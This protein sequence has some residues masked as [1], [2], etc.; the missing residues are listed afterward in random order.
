V[1]VDAVLI[2][3]PAI[4]F[5]TFLGLTHEALGYSPASPGDASH[6]RLSDAERFLS[7]LEALRDPKAVP[8]LRPSLL[9]HV[10][11]SVLVAADDRD[12]IQIVEAAAG[13]PFVR[14]E[15]RARGIDLA[16]VTGTLAQWRD[17]VINGTH[18]GGATQALYSKICTLFRNVG[19]DVWSDCV[20][21]G[22]G[23]VFLI[24]D[25]R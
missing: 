25:K 3:Q 7:C 8:S 6:R 2:Q 14:A 5:A 19:C 23:S 12:M 17:A 13:M 11:F 21:R 24:E 16:V 22:S 20:Q 15:T 4:D 10:S 9:T 1:R 18:K